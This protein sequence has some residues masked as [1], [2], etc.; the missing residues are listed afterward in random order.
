[1]LSRRVAGIIAVTG[2]ACSHASAQEAARTSQPAQAER[3]K[4]QLAILLDTSGSMDGLI[5]QAKSQIWSIVNTFATAEHAGERPE[6]EVALYQYGNDGLSGKEG[7]VQMI[8]GLTTDLDLISEKLFALSTNG[9]EEWC[10]W[11]IRSATNQLDW[12]ESES[13]LRI[14]VIAG[15]E[16]FTQG[17][18]ESAK[19][20]EAAVRKGIIINT[21]FCGNDNEGRNT[22]WYDGAMLGEGQ[23]SHIDQNQAVAEM[24]TPQ[25]AE[26]LT[27]NTQLNGTYIHYGFAGEQMLARQ[28]EAD[29][30]A[31]GLAAGVLQERVAAKASAAYV[32]K[33]WDLVDAVVLDEL[34]V[35]KLKNED[36]PE[37]MREMSADERVKFVEGKRAQRAEIQ[38][39]IQQLSEARTKFIADERAKQAGT[40]AESLGSALSAMV[41]RQAEAKGYTFKE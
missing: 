33:H 19:S 20:C 7:H 36:L 8:S 28:V 1:M 4:V 25:D 39:K 11:A 31:Q 12:S 34:D 6:L 3:A 17:S 5:E 2:L 41:K 26:L 30:S 21:V 9:G 32:N 37:N 24:P 22:G 35:S 14:I 18:V 29:Q 38:Q 10:G 13:D 27:L 15:N 16:A 23:Y 40:E